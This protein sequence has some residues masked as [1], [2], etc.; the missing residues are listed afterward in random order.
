MYISLPIRILTLLLVLVLP[1]CVHAEDTSAIQN[2]PAAQDAPAAQTQPASSLMQTS[3]EANLRKLPS[4]KSD[5]LERVAK[6]SAIELLST[7][8]VGEDTWAYVQIQKSGRSGYML[9]NLL[10]P[11]PNPTPVPTPT[12]VPMATPEPTAT[13]IA[14]LLAGETLYEAPHL[15]RTVTKANI[16]KKPDGDR[17]TSLSTNTLLTVSGEIEKDGKLWLHVS[18]EDDYKGYMLA[19]LT[20]QIQPAVLE[21]VDEAVVREKYPVLSCDPLADLAAMEPFTYTE[22]EL[23]VYHTL[24]VGD[25]EDDVLRLKRR[26]YETGYFVDENDNMNY[27]NST[28][29]VIRMV[30]KDCGL[31]VTGEADPHTQAMLFDERF[32]G[33][34]GSDREIVYLDN[35]FDAPLYIMQ[36]EVTSYSFS[37]AIQ[38]SLRNNSGAKLTRFGFKCIPYWSNGEPAGLAETFAEEIEREYTLGDLS[39]GVG[40]DYSDFYFN[41]KFD[42]GYWP[43]H[44]LIARQTYF[45]GAQ[46]AISSYRSGGYNVYVDDDQMIFVEAGK[47]AGESFIHT[48]PIEITQEEREEAAKWTM[49]VVTR[50][51]LPVYQSYYNLP[52]G[53]W[54]K[55]VASGSPAQ[56]AGL[57]AGDVIVGI[58]DITI[59]GDATLRKARA[60]IQPGDTATLYFWRDGAYYVTELFRPKEQ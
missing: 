53:A 34:P 31:P 10:E 56:D 19:E 3:K 28:A 58:G 48:L 7:L 21:V 57:Q 45:A 42:E 55:S 59:L 40:R 44:F 16:R 38:L 50:Y 14:G 32:T 8:K 47:G 13:P 15:A 20:R 2:A 17:I 41:D 12:A 11:A 22:E 60:A 54:V 49:G 6:G 52:Q 29:E 24:R 27:T 51:V 30:Q 26:L 35:K 37:G 39:V 18:S 1:I 4:V 33:K 36:A 43:H 46:L 5:L 23:A 9:V 25:R